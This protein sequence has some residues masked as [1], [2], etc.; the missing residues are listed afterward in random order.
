M[1]CKRANLQSQQARQNNVNA[2]NTKKNTT[3]F[4]AATAAATP[5]PPPGLSSSSCSNCELWPAEIVKQ[6]KR[7]MLLSWKK[8]RK[9]DRQTDRQQKQCQKWEEKNQE[10]QKKKN[11]KCKTKKRR[12]YRQTTAGDHQALQRKRNTTPDLV[13]LSTGKQLQQR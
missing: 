2:K 6:S 5:P 9:T 7:E 10:N 4:P 13:T 8:E 3:Y 11:T 1:F 12:P